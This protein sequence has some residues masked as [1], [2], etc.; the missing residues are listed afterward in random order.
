[1]EKD[2]NQSSDYD[3]SD[4]Y[5]MA[6]HEGFKV[7]T[8]LSTNKFNGNGIFLNKL[9]FHASLLFYVLLFAEMLIFLIVTFQLIIIDLCV[10]LFVEVDFNNIKEVLTYIVV[11]FILII[12]IPL[13]AIVK[14]SMLDT[15]RYFDEGDNN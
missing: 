7:R 9:N 3:F 4:L 6:K 2:S 12:N 5:K 15:G 11:P 8:S 1:M 14:Y 10:A 13:F